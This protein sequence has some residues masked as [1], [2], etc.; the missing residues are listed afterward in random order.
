MA[1]RA[2]FSEKLP[3]KMAK[4]EGTMAH[5]GE[6]F[7][8]VFDGLLKL[9][10]RSRL[11]QIRERSSERILL[12]K[13]R[14][15]RYAQIFDQED[16]SRHY[17][18]QALDDP[19]LQNVTQTFILERLQFIEDCLGREE[20]AASK[21]MDVGDSSGIFLRAFGKNRVSVNISEAALR[22]IR[23]KNLEVIKGNIESLPLRDRSVDYVLCFEVIEHTPNPILALQE[24]ERVSSKSVFV[25]LPHVSKTTIYPYGYDSTRPPWEC[26]IFEA[27]HRDFLS[28]LSHTGL[29]LQSWKIVEVL[30][31]RGLYEKMAFGLWK[32]FFSRD[33]FYGVLKRFA[34]YHLTK[35]SSHRS[36]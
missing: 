2:L 10:V 27:S 28:L 32:W 24:L 20:I 14:T 15:S 30:T 13:L 9:D 12:R 22:N 35:G 25:S 3:A 33:L 23:G 18:D 21:F 31:P 11:A 16:L 19:G 5:G 36:R 7:K 1:R 26:H 17:G 8:F 29:E 34:V 4:R 6:I